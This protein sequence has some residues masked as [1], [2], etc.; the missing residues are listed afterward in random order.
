MRLWFSYGN[1]TPGTNTAPGNNQNI[2][3]SIVTTSHETWQTNAVAVKD[4]AG[5]HVDMA[6]D[7]GNNVHLAF[8]DGLNGGLYY[9]YIPSTG[10][11]NN[12]VPDTANITVVKVDTY[13]SAGTKLMINVR[14]EGTGAAM[15]YVP[16]ITYLHASFAETRNAVRV[17]WLKTPLQAGGAGRMQVLPGTDDKDFFTGNWE[18][19]TVPARGTALSDEFV[20][21]GVPTGN[22]N[23]LAPVA[24]PVPEGAPAAAALRG[25]GGTDAATSQINQTI[26]VGFMTSDYYE[27][28]VLKYNIL[29]SPG[30]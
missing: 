11:G 1:G 20:C 22:N 10:N 4:F 29:T 25:Y 13:L 12:T 3:G 8:Y 18:V 27:G 14:T 5:T 15:K 21:N 6:V 30:Q 28:A 17:A 24:T 23:W 7:A 19:M 26:L 2:P 9:A 16:Y